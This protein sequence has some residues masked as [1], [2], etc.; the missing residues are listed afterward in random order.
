[1]R[2]KGHTQLS[3]LQLRPDLLTVAPSHCAQAT[4]A[5]LVPEAAGTWTVC[6][7]QPRTA[8][9][10]AQPAT[11]LATQ[12]ITRMRQAQP[13][14][15][16]GGR[17]RDGQVG[18]VRLAAREAHHHAVPL[19]QRRLPPGRQQRLVLRAGHAREASSQVQSFSWV[20]AQ[21][22]A[23]HV[24]RKSVRYCSLVLLGTSPVGGVR[25]LP[26]LRTWLL[27]SRMQPSTSSS[28]FSRPASWSA[29]YCFPSR[30]HSC[31]P[32]YWSQLS[33]PPHASPAAAFRVE[34]VPVKAHAQPARAS[35]TA[36]CAWT[37]TI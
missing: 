14:R 9:R 15:R 25:P 27:N 35:K 28:Y 8:K 12:D 13:A 10:P 24:L 6:N 18:Q 32:R 21:A 3:F 37:G 17:T 20:A 26:S 23:E 33:T 34:Q 16:P 5:M 7:L 19:I 30:M 36:S 4:A 31:R 2:Y 29:A 11:L 1:M 22:P